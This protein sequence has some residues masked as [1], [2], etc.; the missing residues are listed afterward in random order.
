MMQQC[1]K[2]LILIIAQLCPFTDGYGVYMA[3]AI[4]LDN[5]TELIYNACEFDLANNRIGFDDAST[6]EEKIMIEEQNYFVSIYPNPNNGEMTVWYHLPSSNN[7]QML[8]HNALGKLIKQ[9]ELNSNVQQL[10]INEPALENGL[11]YYTIMVDDEIV[12]TD[13]FIIIK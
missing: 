9:Y 3:R 12:K 1:F 4:L 6:E 11:Y 13:K 10:T 2:L 7:T 5:G 8:I